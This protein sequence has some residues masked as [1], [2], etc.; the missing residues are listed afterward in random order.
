MNLD[1]PNLRGTLMVRDA[2]GNLHEFP[3]PLKRVWV[4][5]NATQDMSNEQLTTW[6]RLKGLLR[7][8]EKTAASRIVDY[9]AACGRLATESE[10]VMS[11]K[12]YRVRDEEAG[13]GATLK[14][15]NPDWLQNAI[16]VFLQ[17]DAQIHGDW[18]TRRSA[19]AQGLADHI[20]NNWRMIERADEII[21]PLIQVPDAGEAI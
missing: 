13:I 20:L 21:S 11:P 7:R 6:A 14:A 2:Q 10:S 9:V 1:Y 17:A 8:S 4:C 16:L 15:P 3:H 5:L 19:F 18:Q 12:E